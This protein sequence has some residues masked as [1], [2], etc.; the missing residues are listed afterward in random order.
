MF[1]GFPH[2][3]TGK[4]STCK[5]GELGSIPG[6]KRSPVEGNGYL[7]QYS[8][9]ENS[10]DWS[11][12]GCKELDTAERLSLQ[13]P[14]DYDSFFWLSLFLMT[15]LRQFWEVFC[16]LT[17]H[18]DLPD[19]WLYWVHGFR[20]TDLSLMIMLKAERGALRK[21]FSYCESKNCYTFPRKRFNTVMILHT[22]KWFYF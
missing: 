7:L 4:E 16:K 20:I 18:W 21:A 14:L 12:W 6:L 11:P 13:S 5:A 9:L 3:S 1:L 15:F 19:E 10:M 17:F 8:G 2:D 22:N